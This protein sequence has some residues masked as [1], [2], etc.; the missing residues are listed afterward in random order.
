ML[1]LIL[2]LDL[3]NETKKLSLQP[4]SEKNQNPMNEKLQ[5]LTKK[6]YDEGLEKGKNEALEIVEKAKKEAENILTKAEKDAKNLLEKATKESEELKKIVHSELAISSRQALTSVKQKIAS[7]INEKAVDQALT[8]SFNDK[9]LMKSLM[10]KIAENWGEISKSSQGVI[11]YL[12][13]KDK[14]ELEDFLLKNVAGVISQGFDISFEEGIKSG[15][16]I[17]PKDKSFKISF[18]DKDFE[19]FFMQFLRPRTQKFFTEES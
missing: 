6:I 7:L 1:R 4:D 14:Q 18:T 5:E 19:S 17:G 3:A 2:N 13:E 8:K 16:R 12:P 11:M 15:F 10:L 9:E